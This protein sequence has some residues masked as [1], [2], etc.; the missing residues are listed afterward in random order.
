MSTEQRAHTAL[1][2]IHSQGPVRTLDSRAGQ[3]RPQSF[4][5]TISFRMW[6]PIVRLANTCFNVAFSSRRDRGSRSS[7]RPRPLNGFL[8]G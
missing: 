5:R 7:W 6:R 4:C 8:Y 1:P 3:V 2:R